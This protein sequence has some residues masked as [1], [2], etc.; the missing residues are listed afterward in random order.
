MDG[1]LLS[2]VV[3]Q[4]PHAYHGYYAKSLTKVN[5]NFGTEA[6]LIELVSLVHASKMKVTI[7]VNLNNAG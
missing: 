3:E 7:D 4:M 2:T 6:E 1:V 5:S